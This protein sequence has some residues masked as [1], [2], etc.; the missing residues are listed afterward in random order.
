M[1][2]LEKFFKCIFNLIIVILVIVVLILLYNVVQVNVLK[3]EYVNI[4]G[5]SFFQVATGSMADTIQTNDIV[6]VKITKDVQEGD[7]IT[8]NQNG[9]I[10]THRIVQ[11]NNGKILTKGDA[12]NAVDEEIEY[13]QVIGKV[14][15]IFKDIEVWKNV[16]QTPTVYIPMIITILLFGISFSIKENNQE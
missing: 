2:Y 4:F 11:I 15:Y 9:N 12:N 3:K 16:F 14:V 13:E 1:K 5:Y 7:I 8:F 10:I 6:I